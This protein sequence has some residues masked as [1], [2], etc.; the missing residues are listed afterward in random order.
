MYKEK[1]CIIKRSCPS[2]KYETKYVKQGRYFY[3][4]NRDLYEQQ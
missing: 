1:L 4:F 3:K 2:Y